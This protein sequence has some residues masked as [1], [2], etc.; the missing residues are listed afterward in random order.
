MLGCFYI[1]NYSYQENYLPK[2][3]KMQGHNVEIVAS[4]FT[5]DEKGRGTFLPRA[6]TYI[7]EHGIPVTRLEYARGITSKRLRVYRGLKKELQ[8]IEPDVLFIHGVQF[9]DINVV[10]KYCQKHK[11]VKVYI[12]NHSDYNNSATNWFSK[13]ILHKIIWRHYAKKIN[14]NVEK[15]YGVLPA[16]VDFLVD[17]YKLPKEKV[18]L[19]V[20]GADDTSVEKA[21]LPENRLTMRGKYGVKEDEI[22]LMTGGK[23]NKNKLDTLTL[24]KA[25]SSLRDIP[26]KLLIFGVV[27]PSIQQE[28]DSLVNDNIKF[29]GWKKSEDLYNEF[30]AADILVF[31][32]LHSVLW[33][34]AVG[35]GKP[36]IFRRI[37]GFSHIDIGGNC[38]FFDD[39][40][41]ESYAN[42]IRSAVDNL[43]KME[44]IAKERGLTAFSY[45]KI[46][47]TSIGG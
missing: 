10:K 38:M 2:Y 21:L 47:K 19:L 43:T 22:V 42:T 8:R 15:F 20:M 35:M 46:A 28:F 11:N 26:V 34:Q 37:D 17:V 29:I 36:C 16:R 25:M 31:P 13:N 32:G 40:T 24:M 30:S 12:D 9:K 7:N 14:P 44:E 1:D 18:E 27:D 4:L 39:H 5:F 6:S 23:I 41:A 33:E 45:N 3:H